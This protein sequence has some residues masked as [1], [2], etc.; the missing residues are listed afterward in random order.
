MSVLPMRNWM[1]EQMY[2]LLDRIKAVSER[3][4]KQFDSMIETT[5]AMSDTQK[6]LISDIDKLQKATTTKPGHDRLE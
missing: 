6:N 3:L 5:K 1:Q 2:S 4:E